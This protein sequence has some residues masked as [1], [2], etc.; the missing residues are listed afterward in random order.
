MKNIYVVRDLR[1]EVYNTPFFNE[2]DII[3]CRMVGATAQDPQSLLHLYSKDF[4]LEKIGTWDEM[5]GK[6]V[7]FRVPITIANIHDL[8]NNHN[9]EQHD[10]N[11]NKKTTNKPLGKRGENN[12]LPIQPKQV[13]RNQEHQSNQ[14]STTS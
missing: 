14:N 10:N 12:V 3:A 9:E 4:T 2:N 7:N 13:P 5:T 8:R 6:L 1:A 11:V